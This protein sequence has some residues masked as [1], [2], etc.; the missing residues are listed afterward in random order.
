MPYIAELQ[1]KVDSSQVESATQKLKDFTNATANSAKAE[2]GSRK[3]K[4]QSS[5][6]AIAA[7]Q[8]A[9]KAEQARYDKWFDM[10]SRRD[11]EEASQ[12]ARR[13]AIMAKDIRDSAASVAAK[14]KANARAAASEQKRYDQWLQNADKQTQQEQKQI[15]TVEAARTKAANNA[16]L[17]ATKSAQAIA[18]AEAKAQKD[19]LSE[20][21]RLDKIRYQATLRRYSEEEKL[22]S[23]TRGGGSK[24]SSSVDAEAKSLQ[25]LLAAIDPVTRELQRLDQLEKSLQANRG[26]LTTDQYTKYSGAIEEARKKTEKY[27]DALG[28]TSIT[29]KQLRMAQMGLPAQFTDIVVS[30]QGGQAPL[31]VL[32][33]QGGQIKDMFG[34]VGNAIKGVAGA[35]LPMINPVTLFAAAITA[36]GVAYYQGTKETDA[37][38]LALVSTGNS[39]GTTVA[40]LAAMAQQVDKTIG[41]TGKAAEVIAQLASTGKVGA[42]SFVELAIAAEKWEKAGGQ[43]A[44]ETVKQFAALG[45]DPLDAARKLNDQVNFLTASVY[46]QAAAMVKQGRDTDAATLLQNEYADTLLQRSDEIIDKQGY[47]EKAWHGITGAA[48]EAWDAMLDIGRTNTLEDDL[49]NIVETINKKSAG[50]N[51]FGGGFGAQLP[52][53]KDSDDAWTKRLQ[54]EVDDQAKARGQMFEG[55]AV[56]RGIKDYDD[57]QKGLVTNA[58]K[59]DQLTA[60]LKKIDKQVKSMRTSGFTVS[61][62]DIEKAKTQAREKYKEKGGKKSAVLDDTDVNDFQ[63]KVNEIKSQYAALAEAIKAQQESGTISAEAGFAKRQ[64]LLTDETAKIKAAYQEQIAALEA[65]KGS[66]G[67]SANQVISLDRK[68]A[69]ARSK[70][71]VAEQNAQKDLDKSAA[72][73]EKRLRRQKTNVDAYT[74]SLKQMVDNLKTAGERDRAGIG[75]SERQRGLSG[76]MNSEDD[77][78]ADE[79]RQLNNQRAENPEL[80][81]EVSQKLDLAATAHTKMKDQILANYDEM[82]V[83]QRDWG[84]GIKSAFQ[85]Y[86]EDGSNYANLTN[87]AFSSAFG[88]MEDAIVSF[89]T[90]GKASFSDLAKSILADMARIAVKAAASAALQSIFGA[91]AGAY[92]GGAPAAASSAS[93]NSATAY[94]SG[95]MAAKGAAFTGGTQFFAKG[96]A[97]TNSVVS[98]PTAFSTSSS[99]SNIMGE[100]GPEAIMPLSRGS[101]G[102]LGVRA[103]V[104]VTG[105]QQGASGGGVNVYVNITGDGKTSTSSDDPGYSSFG[106]EIGVFVD[107]R[108]RQLLSK[109]LS[110]GGDIWK[111]QQK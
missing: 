81:G 12:Q 21:Q 102:S 66:K 1:I 30:L 54:Q 71:V 109:D 4:E 101:D 107:Q 31:T 90:T 49:D 34:G 73:E 42:T 14:E 36:V 23:K 88:S 98:K 110:P 18:S 17:A 16:Q 24:A 64:Q 82:T 56:K 106:N 89:V 41:T 53:Q 2:D 28:R 29:S 62:A 65:L 86:I 32:L 104:D 85:Q 9:S 77:R 5:A 33:Q 69:D 3:A 111:S 78:Y 26:R 92:A 91:V 48:K 59:A 10:A 108:Y 44:S 63:N 25:N 35:I 99:N 97:F 68:I 40:T 95:M 38:R 83:A 51:L 75:Q 8:K 6:K 37:F 20:Q 79:V 93:M 50:I 67:I 70:M 52:S 105:L 57:F 39:A 76:Q 45:D 84:A 87:Q 11:K 61:D 60:A 80:A 47:V 15:A 7:E 72:A 74:A 46:Q 13:D 27:N 96:G 43:A 58:D 100:A 55:E 22:A 19:A 94:N 103:S